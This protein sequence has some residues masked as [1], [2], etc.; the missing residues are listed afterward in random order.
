MTISP[1]TLRAILRE[2]GGIP[3][4][5]EEIEKVAPAVSAFVAEFSRLQDLDLT[6]VYSALQLRAED[7]G[8]SDARK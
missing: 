6:D 4:S 3:M 5:D 2:Y 7:G 1:D 8:F